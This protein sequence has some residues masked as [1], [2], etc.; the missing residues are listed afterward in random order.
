MGLAVS[1]DGFH[2]AFAR[3]NDPHPDHTRTF[4]DLY[5][6]PLAGG[7]PR[8]LTFDNEFVVG[9]TWTP[10]S[11][12]IVFSC[13]RSAKQTYEWG[14]T[15]WRVPYRGGEP[16]LVS[17]AFLRA[18]NPTISKSGNRLV[19]EERQSSPA[20]IWRQDLNSGDSK[21]APAARIIGS[22]RSDYSPQISPDSTRLAVVSFRTG[23]N[24]IWLS[25]PDGANAFQLT[26]LD[27][28]PA[29]P[30]WSFDGTRIVFRSAGTKSLGIHV[31]DVATRA[32]RKLG[33][34]YSEDG[35]P[36]WSGDGRWIYFC[37]TRTGSPQIWKMPVD[38][39]KAVQVTQDG[40]EESQVSPDGRF[41]Y[42]IR[43]KGLSW[44][45]RETSLWKIPV[46]GG[47]ETLVMETIHSGYW[48]LTQNGM[49]YLDT[50]GREEI[51][52]PIQFLDFGSG[53]KRILTQLRTE[54]QWNL[55]SISASRD[56]QWLVY[57]DRE[58]MQR[59]LILVE[60]IR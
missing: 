60:N 2:V 55:T 46:E 3:L 8:R 40:G 37:S 25:D 11:Q 32:A 5:V 33:T 53:K 59:D 19:Y 14:Y 12:E 7:V 20:K 39:G 54:P 6:M 15:L 44:T 50:T 36:N 30:R 34:G 9:M 35:F 18:N 28:E 47:P 57:P 52:F 1:P 48:S 45:Y 41:L 17:S 38:D 29:V 21:I 42:F 26:N 16:H 10:D 58:R 13:F 27:I 49:C 51:P 43:S 31:V 4:M 22:A 24:E 56:G 23:T